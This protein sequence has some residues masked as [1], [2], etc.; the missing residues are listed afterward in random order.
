M[1]ERNEPTPEPD[2]MLYK[3][4]LDPDRKRNRSPVS[5]VSEDDGDEK[6]KRKRIGQSDCGRMT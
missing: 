6:G 1:S 4:P 3:Q 2:L 5:N